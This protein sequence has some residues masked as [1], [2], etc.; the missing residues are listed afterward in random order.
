ARGRQRDGRGARHSQEEPV[1]STTDEKGL[2]LSTG[3]AD[4]RAAYERGIDLFLR[5]RG[6]A[7]D[8]LDAATQSAPHFSLPLWARA[9]IA[10]RMG[11]VDLATA[12][13]ERAVA[14]RDERLHE[15]EVGHVEAVGATQRGD[16][17]GAYG[18]LDD[19]VARY[20]MDRMAVRLVGLHCITRGD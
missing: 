16:H 8:A 2:P 19:L 1:V 17:A 14:L 12:A 4:A 9:Q 13:A 10:W 7:M 6:G 18:I 5:W 15:R 11:R 20:P 3:S